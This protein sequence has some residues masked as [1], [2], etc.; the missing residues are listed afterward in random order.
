MKYC[1]KCGNKIKEDSKFCSICGNPT[2]IEL[3]RREEE[4]K[5]I[6]EEKKDKTLLYLGAGLIIL[7][8]IIFAFSNWEN[9]SNIFKIAFLCVEMIIFL[10]I[11]IFSKKFGENMPYK[12]TWAIGVL[13]VPIILDLIAEYEMFGL[14]NDG[15]AINVYLS[16]SYLISSLVFYF[17]YKYIKSN[18][19]MYLCFASIYCMIGSIIEI[20]GVDIE[21]NE[22]LFN[23]IF[24][25]INLAVVIF[26]NKFKNEMSILLKNFMKVMFII[27]TL[28]LCGSTP[29]ENDNISNILLPVA[30]CA[31]HAITV[32]LFMKNN[33][34]KGLSYVFPYLLYFLLYVTLNGYFYNNINIYVFFAVTLAITLHLIFNLYNSKVIK[35]T[36]LALMILYIYVTLISE[37][38]SDKTFLVISLLLL[39]S[40]LF[41]YKISDENIEK[42]V[43]KILLP[44][45]LLIVIS[46]IINILTNLG[47]AIIYIIA[48]VIC[49]SI[50]TILS[51][52]SNEKQSLVFE[53]FSYIYLGI[54]SIL[55]LFGKY[56]NII[57]IINEVLWLYYLIS[58]MFTNKTIIKNIFL[59]VIVILNLIFLSIKFEMPLYY[60]FLFISVI[61]ALLEISCVKFKINSNSIYF[62]ISLI[63]TIIATMFNFEGYIVFAV[64]INVLVYCMIYYLLIGKKVPFAIKYIYTI[65][66]FCLISRLFNY[67]INQSVIANI[68]VLIV[69]II[70]IISMFLLET[71][72]DNRVLS[73]TPV[74]AFPYS[75]LVNNIGVLSG[76]KVEL[77]VLLAVALIIL[78]MEKVFNIKN[79]KDR[80][81]VELILISFIHIFTI[82]TNII[83]NSLIAIFY[84][85]FGIFKKK[86]SFIIL[87]VVLLLISIFINLFEI[88]GSLSIIY[89][90]LG[91][92]VILVTY[93]FITEAKKNNKK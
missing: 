73:Y 7:S 19:M 55:I 54:S 63:S 25:F 34:I 5:K 6:K 39:I 56:S 9:M 18:S 24:C 61:F 26:I 72:T 86:D 88:M 4:R 13:F 3:E 59:L 93:V 92:G 83:F 42:E 29:L 49:F 30:T 71:D 1:T 67:F 36:S 78:F 2:K 68:I 58:R 15:N 89:I 52:K 46:S 50:Y 28:F 69:Y 31:I 14:S 75:Y 17:S 64:C 22:H 84:I 37:N 62:Y 76:F 27:M 33:D 21:E 38:L 85:F 11:S 70:I 87:G 79:E 48:S 12:I 40:N 44:V 16:I 43:S 60:T 91:I 45:T 74:V 65:F 81:L 35:L 82:Y 10:L 90:L 20:F 66:G 23:M 51:I 80:T 77:M 8:S 47:E 41:I 53:I 32:L 57:F